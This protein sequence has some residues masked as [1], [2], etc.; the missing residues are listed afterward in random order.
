MKRAIVFVVLSLLVACGGAQVPTHNGYKGKKPKPWEKAKVLKLEKNAA[1]AD[2][3][4][5]YARFKRA[6]WLAIDT[7][8]PGM[9]TVNIDVTPSSGG[10]E[11]EEGEALDMD[12]GFEILDGVSWNV[13]AKSN[14]E[15]DDAHE[16]KKEHK[17]K[18]LA[19]GR[20][21]IHLYLEGR[22]DVADVDVKVAFERGEV[23]WKSD[24]PNQVAFA[25]SLAAVPVFDD[26]PEVVVK[27]KTRVTRIT[28]DKPRDK[29]KPKDKDTGGAGSVMAEISDT[30]P[31]GGGGTLITIGGGTADGLENGL[32]GSV[33]GVRGSSFKLSGCGAATCRAKVKAAIDDVRAAG[34]VVIKL[35][36]P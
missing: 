22:L 36:A 27:K 14:L 7:P 10:G 20:Y 19:E 6:K 21:Y 24:F 33:R 15:T 23:A 34:A 13:L 5:D 1:K 17:L 31:D 9:L 30:Q 18:D 11:D 29:D 2:V 8:G 4:L 16:L 35:K 26:S 12:V 3:D 28:D 32:S 25:D